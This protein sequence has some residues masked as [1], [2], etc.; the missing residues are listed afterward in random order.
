MA[1]PGSQGIKSPVML[2]GNVVIANV[3]RVYRNTY[4]NYGA[5]LGLLAYNFSVK[6][7]D[8]LSGGNR[9]SFRE[10]STIYLRTNLSIWQK[11]SINSKPH[12]IGIGG[13]VTV[14]YTFYDRTGFTFEA[15][16]D[17]QNYTVLEAALYKTTKPLWFLRASI[18]KPVGSDLMFGFEYTHHFSPVLT[19]WYEFSHTSSP[20]FGSLSVYQR[21]VS[22]TALVR[23]SKKKLFR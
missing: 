23:I 13:G 16:H 3:N 5:G 15:A 18:F 14:Q 4:I 6:L 8:T 1:Q 11:V 21:E 20:S 22:L 12:F 9:S 7:L 19:G 17:N 10:I 2:S